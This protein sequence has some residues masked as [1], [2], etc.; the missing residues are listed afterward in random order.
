MLL[1]REVFVAKPGNASKLAK[2]FKDTMPMEDAAKMRI[3]TDVVGPYNTVVMEYE[4]ESLSTWEAESKEWDKKVTPE[5]QQ[6]M[7]GY[8]EMYMEGRREV[9]RIL[10]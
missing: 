6:K 9:F 5:M 7:A 1:V 2:L 10:E 4:T 8:T 3:M